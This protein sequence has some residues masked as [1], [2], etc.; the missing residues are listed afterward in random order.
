M[1]GRTILGVAGAVIGFVVSGYN[2]YGAQVGWMIGPDSG[3]LVDGG[4]W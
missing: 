4:A 1:S 3:E 2:P